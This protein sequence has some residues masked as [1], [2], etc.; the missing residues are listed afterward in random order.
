MAKEE[1]NRLLARDS[2][3]EAS[4]AGFVHLSHDNALERVFAMPELPEVEVTRRQIAV[5]LIGARIRRVWVGPPSYFFVSAPDVLTKRL[6]GRTVLAVVRHGKYLLLELDDASRLLLHLGM[7]GQLTLRELPDSPHIHLR[8]ELEP[9]SLLSFRDVRKFGKVEWIAPGASSPRLDKLGPDALRIRGAVFVAALAHRGVSI[10]TAL[11]D[12]GVLAGVG[13]IYADE[14]LFRAGL[15]PRRAARSLQPQEAARLLVEVR[16]V[17]RASIQRG[18]STINDYLQP[19]GELGGYQ[20][21]HQVYGK[22]G[23]PCARCRTPLSRT[24]LGG[25]STHFCANCQR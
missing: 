15:D 22:G 6:K 19:D 23:Q 8:L 11:L 17:L 12:Q 24:V 1:A 20:G 18:G 14:A 3:F 16:R 2:L 21:W 9:K 25:R 7:T 10:K 4:G 5:G 13:N